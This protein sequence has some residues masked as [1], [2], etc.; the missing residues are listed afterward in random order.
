M[1]IMVV[2]CIYEGHKVLYIL[3]NFG[4]NHKTAMSGDEN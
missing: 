4:F 1:S 3:N 2:S